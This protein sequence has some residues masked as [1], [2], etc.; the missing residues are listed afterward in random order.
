MC[1]LV[2]KKAKYQKNNYIYQ[3]KNIL[4]QFYFFV[5]TDYFLY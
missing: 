3:I 5:L 1:Q 4:F 2:D